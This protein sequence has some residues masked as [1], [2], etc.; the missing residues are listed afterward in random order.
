MQS[1]PNG[2]L[3][4]LDK[5]ID[6]N[7]NFIIRLNSENIKLP[8]HVRTKKQG[9][10]ILI[11]NMNNKKKVKEIF[12]ECKLNNNERKVW[13]IVTDDNDEIIW[14]PGLKKSNLDVK[15]SNKYD[16]IIKYNLK[17]R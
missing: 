7:S 3:K 16:I 13:P 17:E 2:C 8:L 4:V 6:D 15:K 14:I 10:K 1:L 11:K 12:I 9:D 5:D